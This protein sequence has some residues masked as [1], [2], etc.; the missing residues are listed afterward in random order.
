[1]DLSAG[2]KG[3]DQAAFLNIGHRGACAYA[4]EN[5]AVSIEEAVSRCADMVEFDLRQTSDGVIVLFHDRTIATRSGKRV[6]VSRISFFE[7]SDIAGAAGYRL[8]I[9]E[10][11]LREFGSRV[12][13]DIEIKVRG[14]EEKVIRLLKKYPPAFE[15]VISSFVPGV[16]E[17]IKRLDPSVKTGLVLGYSKIP[18]LNI[19]ARPVVSRLISKVGVHSVHLHKS[20]VSNHILQELF[21]LGARVYIWTVN[22][23]D[24]MIRLLKAGV[25]GIVTDTPDVL[26]DICRNLAESEEPILSSSEMSGSRFLYAAQP[27][28][29]L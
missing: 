25:D 8:S 13:L 5:T 20:L 26:Y 23:R 4:P 14:F 16:I 1:M 6:P 18:Q 9:F 2:K 7:L 21:V 29:S 19:F 3:Q 12:P 22:D 11:I 10:E 15:P 17:R 28:R 27:S 24:E